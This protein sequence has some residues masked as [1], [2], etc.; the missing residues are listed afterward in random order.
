[1]KYLLSASLGIAFQRVMDLS[2]PICHEIFRN[3][4]V[5]SCS[6]SFCQ[7]CLHS[8]WAEDL[9]RECPL[10][11]RTASK[12]DPVCNLALRNLCETF[13]Q[14][15]LQEE[16]ESEALCSLHSEKLKLFC[17][18]HQ[19]PVCVVCRDSRAHTNHRFRPI[20]EAAEDYKKELS[21]FLKPL[22]EKLEV[23]KQ[24]KGN[25]DQT[26]VH[27][28]V[29]ALHTEMQIKDEIK[30]LRQFL[31][32]EEEART[33]AVR[34]EEDQKSQ[35]MKEK[36]NGLTEDIVALS[37]LVRA[38]EKEIK[39]GIVP[40]L[41]NYKRTLERVQQWPL[42][43]DPQLAPGALIDM[44]KHLGNLTFNIWNKMTEMVTYYPVILDP[45]TA[46][47]NLRL[48]KNLT[49][50]RYSETEREREL[51][52][53]P[54]RCEGFLT[55]LGSE[56]FNSGTYGWEIEGINNADWTVGVI[57][58]SAPKK[59]E[60]LEGHWGIQFFNGEH[61]AYSPSNADE[62]LCVKKSLHRV[63]V[64]LDLDEG[65]LSFHDPDSNTNIHTF[66]HTFTE[67]LFPILHTASILPMKI[68]P[69]KVSAKV[70]IH[71]S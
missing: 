64:H 48:S 47:T 20:D 63:R 35:M 26:A 27:I 30:R 21:D 40:F 70:E 33:A 59:G 15:F 8:W 5:L 41:Q 10:C 16:R 58:E 38:T 65:K 52:R 60:L 19:R 56:G 23:L 25:W 34:K 61:R 24:I 55:V 68:S 51:P 50:A 39:T 17:L 67:R 14:D 71:R 62:V 22:Q 12:T 31:Q 1:M 32:E 53:N 54:E 3:P 45:N 42:L 13:L 4:V 9:N 7:A 6:H 44:A 28:N 18:D 37:D 36:I 2:C 46:N 49:S 11:R 57:A 43:D 66:R 29:Q 69:V